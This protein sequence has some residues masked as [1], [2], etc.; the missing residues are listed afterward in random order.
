M[1]ATGFVRHAGHRSLVKTR[2]RRETTAPIQRMVQV[3]HHPNA[4][5]ITLQAPQNS[6][7]ASR[8]ITTCG[9]DDL[10]SIR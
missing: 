1:S 3:P 2:P 8:K 9:K 4:P 5:Q 10:A 7:A 6:L